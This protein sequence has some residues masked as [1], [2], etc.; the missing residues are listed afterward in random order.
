MLNQSEEEIL[1]KIEQ[2]AHANELHYH[3]CCQST[4]EAI[5]D[6]LGIGNLATF[7]AANSLYFGIARTGDFC[8]VAVAGI[9]AI[10][11][12]FGREDFSETPE[13]P[14]P[15]RMHRAMDLCIEFL[16]KFEREIGSHRCW[17]IQE[18]FLGRRFDSRDPEIQKMKEAGTY[19]P[20][21]GEGASKVA[22]KGARLAAEIILRERKK[23][24]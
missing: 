23:R 16:E 11:I 12:E 22:G 17:D 8:G 9:M 15:T 4:L 24:E 21:L 20:A 3:G 14:R 2:Q 19:Y 7:K 6:H 13:D 10:G 1:D 18:K 5:Q